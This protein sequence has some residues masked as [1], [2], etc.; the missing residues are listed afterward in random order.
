MPSSNS[1]PHD[2][3]GI[4]ASVPPCWCFLSLFGAASPKRD[5]PR[6]PI[7]R[8]RATVMR[9][10]SWIPVL[11]LRQGAT[12]TSKSIEPLVSRIGRCILNH[13]FNYTTH[14]RC[15]QT[16]NAS[17]YCDSIAMLLRFYC[18]CIFLGYLCWDLWDSVF[19]RANS[20]LF[21]C[22]LSAKEIWLSG[23]VVQ[24]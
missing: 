6:T 4:Y 21:G 10:K 12:R 13:V 19:G 11:S 16:E 24:F 15:N 22:R 5:C 3:I 20:S 23:R 17:K 18:C 7:S 9:C 2:R 8:F 14:F 1:P